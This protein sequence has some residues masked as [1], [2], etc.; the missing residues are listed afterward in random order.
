MSIPGVSLSSSS[1]SSPGRGRAHGHVTDR[2]VSAGTS[3]TRQY[4][5]QAGSK[6]K[7]LALALSTTYTQ[8]HSERETLVSTASYFT[9]GTDSGSGLPHT[10]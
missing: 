5:P 4:R 8:K 2:T 10:H 3:A 6:E 7:G 9:A 1:S